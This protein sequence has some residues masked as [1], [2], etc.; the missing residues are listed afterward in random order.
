MCGPP[1][2]QPTYCCT[3]S[4]LKPMKCG[5]LYRRRPTSNGS[6]WPW[7]PPHV[8]LLRF[9]LV[10]AAARVPKPCGLRS[11]RSIKTMQSFIP[12]NMKCIRA[13]SQLSVTKPSR[14]KHAKPT[15][16]SASTTRCGNAFHVSSAPHYPSPRRWR[17]TSVPSSS[18]FATTTWRKR[19]H[20]LC[21]TTDKSACWC[22]PHGGVGSSW[23]WDR[24]ALEAAPPETPCL[25]HTGHNEAGVVDQ[26]LEGFRLIGTVALGVERLGL[27]RCDR[28]ALA[29]PR[30]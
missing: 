28:S 5:A 30:P 24:A 3:S 18:L 25:V 8:R 11:L 22:R 1:P 19:Q 20:Y 14:N 15:T 16:S 27:D 17:T 7:T 21:S 6:G 29:W 4:R 23:A 26:P 2:G 9:T 10:I 13:S 12:I